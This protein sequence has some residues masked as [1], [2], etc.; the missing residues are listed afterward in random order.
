MSGIVGSHPLASPEAVQSMVKQLKHRGPDGHRVVDLQAGSLGGGQQPMNYDQHWI[1]FNGEIY[2]HQELRHRYLKE[3]TLHTHTDTEVLLHLYDLLGPTCVELLDGLFALALISGDE[4]LLARDPLGAKPLYTGTRGDTLYFA[5]EIKALSQITDDIHEFPAGH[6]YHSKLGWKQYYKLD[7]SAIVYSHTSEAK[8]LPL[9][10]QTIA[11]AVHKR[12]RSDAPLGVSLSGGL[13]SSI[14]SLLAREGLEQLNSFAVGVEDGDD[15]PAARQ[16]A[17]V[18]GAQH[19]EFI[20][21]EQDMQAV[22]PQVIYY[23]ES[24]DPA[25]VRSAIPNYFLARL[26]A[27]HVKVFLTGE[28]ADELYAGYSYLGAFDEPAALQAE[29]IYIITALHNTNLQ[30]GDRMAMAH[31]L[32]VRVPFLDTELIAFALSLPPAWKL[33]RPDRPEKSLLRRAFADRLPPE[34]VNRPKQKF[35]QGAGSAQIM[36]RRAEGTISDTEFTA[37]S[38]RL[39]ADWNYRLPSKEALYYY[40][41]L[42]QF[43]RDEWILPEMGRSRSI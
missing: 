13:D 17:R 39:A 36:V 38:R 6:W 23:L 9:I 21:T 40:K 24:F 34:I 5:S 20:Y 42:R 3:H 15:L 14:V 8:V 19:H 31:G 25:L 29:L 41:I 43:Y 22:L 18:L 37:E 35:S 33:H 2:N 27:E 26:A 7:E 30:R 12:L 16:M 1:T 11:Q 32:E 28:G 10:R 4:L